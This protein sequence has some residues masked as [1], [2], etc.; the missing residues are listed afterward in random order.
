MRVQAILAAVL[1]AGMLVLGGC[2]QDRGEFPLSTATS[3]G[4]SGLPVP[5][6]SGSGSDSGTPSATATADTGTST[7]TPGASAT[8]DAAAEA[9]IDDPESI[10]VIV[11]KT[12]PLDPVDYAPDDLRVVDVPYVY[13]PMMRDEAATA[14]EAMFAAFADETG[15]AMQSQ[16]AY[17]SYSSQKSVYA[18]WVSSLGKAQADIQS[19][20]PGYSEHQTGLAIDISAKPAKCSLAA[21]FADTPQGEWLAKNAWEY[22]FVLRYPDGYTDV[23]GYTFEPWH[24]RYIGVELAAE[25]HDSGANTL[26]EFFGLPDAPTYT[27]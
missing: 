20:R 26:E 24:Y 7:A 16:S 13:K 17:R 6:L 11:N 10:A 19:A 8:G 9:D 21:C 22:G 4:A 14:V 2:A 27:G 15:L 23:T 1:A 3:A 25:Y 18:G 5:Q 12:R